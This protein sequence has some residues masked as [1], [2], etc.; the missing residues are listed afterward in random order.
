MK[1]SDVSG[2]EMYTDIVS[3]RNVPGFFLAVVAAVEDSE[4]VAVVVVA[5]SVCEGGFLF[6]PEIKRVNLGN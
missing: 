6:V 5:D 2:T 4:A 3:I 1:S